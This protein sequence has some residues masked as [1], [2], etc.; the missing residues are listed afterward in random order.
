MKN[1]LL[2]ILLACF[3]TALF[4]QQ[5]EQ[6]TQFMHYKLGLN[7]AY[8]GKD[9][10]PSLSALVRSQWLGIDGAP[11]T[12]LITFNTP[13]MNNR[14][15]VGATVTRQTIGVTENYT[16][17]GNYAYH[18]RLGRGYLGIGIQAS[19]RLMRVDFAE[20]TGTQPI[21]TDGAIPASYQ[22]KYVPNFGAGLY[23]TGKNMY[24]GLSVPRLMASNIDLASSNSNEEVQHL[25]LMGGV[26][27]SLSEKIQLQPQLLLKYVAGTPF[28][29]DV[30]L[31][32]VFSEKITTGVSYRLGGSKESSIGESVSVL[33]GAQ[34]SE[35][36]MLGASYDLTLSKLKNYNTGS[37]EVVIRYFFGG[38]AEEGGFVNPRFF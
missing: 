29:G 22:S 14:A 31:S 30:N 24:V 1:L 3:S 15:G 23:Y 5:E 32:L 38:G 17:D 2:L 26:K 11:Q 12:Q 19:V 7:P 6:Y 34:I 4:A 27:F 25:Y 18:L 35:R 36:L 21:D 13:L 37:I 8:A 10:A 28:D 33:F 16:V 20:L 9:G